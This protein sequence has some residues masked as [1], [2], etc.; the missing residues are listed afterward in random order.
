[1]DNTNQ[2][3]SVIAK[4]PMVPYDTL[5]GLGDVQSCGRLDGVGGDLVP[6]QMMNVVMTG[7]VCDEHV[8]PTPADRPYFSP[9]LQDVREYLARPRV[10]L[11]P[12]L[13]S[14][15]GIAQSLNI[16]FLDAAFNIKQR[17][18]G[19]LGWK[20]TM[21]F[22]L[23]VVNTPYT[24]GLFRMFF[25]PQ[26]F[27]DRLGVARLSSVCSQMH[28]VWLDINDKT[29]AVLKVPFTHVADFFPLE[30]YQ[31]DPPYG[32]LSLWNFIPVKTGAGQPAPSL[33]VWGH[34]EDVEVFGT[35]DPTFTFQSGVAA[36]EQ[37]S[38]GSLTNYPTISSAMSI[39]KGLPTLQGVLGTTVGAARAIS[40]TA[41]YFGW[42]KPN[43]MNNPQW[44][45]KTKNQ[46]T[47]NSDGQD[48]SYVLGV[49]QANSLEVL[50]DGTK[51]TVDEMA[52][53]YIIQQPAV[54]ARFS[55]TTTQPVDSV[56]Y[57][58]HA[59]PY[60]ACHYYHANPVAGT[61][62]GLDVFGRH[63]QWRAST[64]VPPANSIL[65]TTPL[66][67]IAQNFGLWRGSLKLKFRC[68]KTKFHAGRLRIT[69][70]PTI[71]SNGYGV[72]STATIDV[73]EVAHTKSVVWDLKDTNELEFVIPYQHDKY[74]CPF[75][76]VPGVVI[77]TVLEKLTAPTTV[78]NS[79]DFLV[80]ASGC[81]DTEFA[82]LGSPLGLPIAPIV[83][84]ALVAA[85]SL[86]QPLGEFEFQS[87]ST[88]DVVTQDAKGTV[89]TVG[90]AVTSVKQL[91][92]V[93]TRMP[94]PVNGTIIDDINLIS[95][96]SNQ[97]TATVG[98]GAFP[99]YSI[100]GAMYA[101]FRGSS[102]YGAVPLARGSNSKVSFTVYNKAAAMPALYDDAYGASV[103]EMGESSFVRLPFF[104][105]HSKR[106]TFN[107]TNSYAEASPYVLYIRNPSSATDTGFSHFLSFRAADDFQLISFQCS[108]PIQFSGW[109]VAFGL[110]SSY[111]ANAYT[112][113][114]Q[115]VMG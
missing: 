3:N 10:I 104:N 74:W 22:T 14:E 45:R 55:M 102:L 60:A 72:S 54:M 105:T 82:L 111:N 37:R 87:M 5:S 32:Y 80:E 29:Q 42:S 31:N 28:G 53:S 44:I 70:V 97:T 94:L 33:I 21:V 96:L 1:M 113:M 76:R 4:D 58:H 56:L 47:N 93:E 7:E 59:T 48:S 18:R 86:E 75:V 65:Y 89:F 35:Y 49:S 40:K 20:A 34:L 73:D 52:F 38:S 46:L 109:G 107:P 9:V 36:R 85:P 12:S 27:S 90:E 25:T 106:L 62:N 16:A 17:L 71:S 6:T 79:I 15:T 8:A 63:I 103:T 68:A 30:G 77:V 51:T 110:L 57:N 83:P 26:N 91:V 50:A 24:S 112:A 78:A 13:L 11:R 2:N 67:Y 100:F 115:T 88:V 114:N 81:P 19:C 95:T 43:N 61:G 41:D 98:S 92:S 66:F 101:Y 23:Q 108:P 99:R 84:A 39:V 69:F 64:T